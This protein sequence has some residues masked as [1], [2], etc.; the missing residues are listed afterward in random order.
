MSDLKKIFVYLIALLLISNPIYFTNNT[1]AQSQY[2]Q[3]SEEL[4]IVQ[5]GNAAYWSITLSDVNTTGILSDNLKNFNG[6]QSFYFVNI[7]T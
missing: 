5:A 2:D 6:I 3:Y 7:S 4:S 1:F